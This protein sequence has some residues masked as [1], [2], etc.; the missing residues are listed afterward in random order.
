MK[1]SSVTVTRRSGSFEDLELTVGELHFPFE[2]PAPA[3]FVAEKPSLAGRI[4]V[5]RNKD[6]NGSDLL[7][8]MAVFASLWC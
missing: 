5:W 7:N 2:I 4:A 8:L 6:A 1:L 3:A